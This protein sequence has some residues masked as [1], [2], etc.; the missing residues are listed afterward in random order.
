MTLCSAQDK[1]LV[2]MPGRKRALA[3]SCSSLL[4][5]LI[6]TSAQA[7]EFSA[8]IVS[9]NAADEV[10]GPPGGI[11]V[12]GRKARIESP[13]LPGF[14]MIVDS[15]VPAAYVVRPSARVYM[16]AMQSSR[17]TRLLVPLD[18]VDPCPQWET[19][20]EVAGMPDQRGQWHCVAE[21]EDTV[22]ARRALKFSATSPRGHS[23]AWVDPVLKFPIK[24]AI[25]DG[26]VVAL[27]DIREG[28]Q[29]ADNFTIPRGYGKY[30]VQQLIERI[31]HS[32]IWVEPPS[33][34]EVEKSAK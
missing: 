27:R 19:M 34:A 22:D 28:P 16:N 9:L 5:V 30:D 2:K 31:K 7:Q 14:Y 29:P 15:S 3:P 25:E 10:V 11:N 23:T 4:L 33:A 13:D 32:D 26:T 24:I 12:S 8:D 21:G 17:L 18:N 6:A 1:K 20:A